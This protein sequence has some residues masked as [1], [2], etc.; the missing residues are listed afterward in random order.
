MNFLKQET[1]YDP[2][3][4]FEKISLQLFCA[5][6]EFKN[7]TKPLEIKASI[8]RLNELEARRDMIL[9]IIRR[10]IND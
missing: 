10:G 2:I 5:E 6:N 4:E 9:N 7:A 1:A 3:K 8:F